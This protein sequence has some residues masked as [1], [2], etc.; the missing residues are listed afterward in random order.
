MQKFSVD[1]VDQSG[2]SVRR[3]VSAASLAEAEQLV[4]QKGM[5]IRAVAAM[6]DT[7]DALAPSNQPAGAEEVAWQGSPSQWL[8]AGWFAACILLIPIPIAI[9]KYFNLRNMSFTLTTQR[10]K[11]EEGVLA[12]RYDQVELYRV[13]DAVLTRSLV[14]RILGLGTIRM[15]TSDPSMP[16]LIVPSISDSENVR[17][18]IRQN[19]ERMRRLRGVRELDVADESPPHLGHG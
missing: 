13:K 2:R 19:V 16:E 4:A 6:D 1:A 18:L 5:Q 15:I 14:Q 3:I 17:E 10:I 8:N 11:T 7:P 12:K 9:W